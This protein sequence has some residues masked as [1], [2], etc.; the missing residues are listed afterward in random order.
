[1][2]FNSDVVFMTVINHRGRDNLHSFFAGIHTVCDFQWQPIKQGLHPL[3]RSYCLGM[4]LRF[5][6]EVSSIVSYAEF[7]DRCD[8]VMSW[9]SSSFIVL[10]AVVHVKHLSNKK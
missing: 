3:R 10:A 8:I 4:L 9:Q 1:M 2:A 5:Y 7:K 6:P